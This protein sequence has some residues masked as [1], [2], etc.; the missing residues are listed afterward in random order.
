MP[1]TA[2][3]IKSFFAANAPVYEQKIIPAFRQFAESVILTAQPH[4]H[5]VTL[6]VGTGTGILARLIAPQVKSVV[7]VDIATEM[8]MAADTVEHPNNVR[9]QEGDAHALPFEDQTFDLVVSSFGLNATNPRQAF[10]E[11]HRVL[12]QDGYFVFH[13]W[14]IQHHLDNQIQEVMA[15]YMLPD[16]DVSDELF[17]LREFL[18]SPRMW[19]NILQEV[20]D[21]EEALVREGFSDIQVMED[22]PVACVLHYEDFKVYKM[23]W[24]GRQ[25]EL[26]EMHESM[27]GD[28]LDALRDLLQQEAD[29]DGYIHYDPLLFRI[30]AKR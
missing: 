18:R 4:G 9:F 8:I 3:Q 27:R 5:E 11:A 16:E 24:A 21:Y 25:M 1:R 13:E 7:G 15:T 17:E 6:D 26:A 23:A 10:K 28:C 14:S 12:K 30:K 22:K 19:D 2:D 29:H 20:E